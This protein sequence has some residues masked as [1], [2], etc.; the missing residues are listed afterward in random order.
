MNT[1]APTI[2]DFKLP[3]T[4]VGVPKI[5]EILLTESTSAPPMALIDSIDKL[6]ENTNE[7]GSQILT[8][9]SCAEGCQ[10]YFIMFTV[11][12]LI[13][14]FFGSTGRIGNVLLNYR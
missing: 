11:I 3:E 10:F 9:G 13:V 5:P 7:F 12:S 8:V 4:T 6:M 14:N 1:I 2:P